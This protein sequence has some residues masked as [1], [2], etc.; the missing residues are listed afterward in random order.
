MIR[1][2]ERDWANGNSFKMTNAKNWT[3]G[4]DCDYY[5][6][7][8]LMILLVLVKLCMFE[9]GN[10]WLLFLS[11]RFVII[12]FVFWILIAILRWVLWSAVGSSEF[13]T[14]RC[15]SDI[16]R[17][18]LLLLLLSSNVWSA[19][20]V[21]NVQRMRKMWKKTFGLFDLRVNSSCLQSIMKI[22]WNWTQRY[23]ILSWLGTGT[24]GQTSCHSQIY[25]HLQAK[26]Y[27]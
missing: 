1:W 14:I 2:T 3:M 23:C 13:W 5:M 10:V 9:C 18:V 21:R 25:A 7:M 26:M 20:R 24:R 8:A 16:K 12:P 22:V 4:D 15:C 17:I 6:A 27:T 11:S 19:K